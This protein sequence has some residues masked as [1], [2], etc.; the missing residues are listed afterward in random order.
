MTLYN[1]LFLQPGAGASS[2]G[3]LTCNTNETPG[4]PLPTSLHVEVDN[5]APQGQHLE[6][7][8]EN[9]IVKQSCFN[10]SLSLSISISMSAF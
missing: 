8:I 4:D 6:D 5:V 7:D 2:S 9:D 1:S 3:G 10:S